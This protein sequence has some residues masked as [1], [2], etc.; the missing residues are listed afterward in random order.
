MINKE[1]IYSR[2]RQRPIN[3]KT[4]EINYEKKKNYQSNLDN[5]F[6]YDYD[7]HDCLDIHDLALKNLV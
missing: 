3:N 6:Y 5:P 2:N 1:L 7:F 4:N